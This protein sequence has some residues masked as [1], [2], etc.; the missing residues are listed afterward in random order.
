MVTRAGPRAKTVAVISIGEIP[1]ELY[2][3][4]KGLL[5]NFS[6]LRVRDSRRKT[7]MLRNGRKNGEKTSL[8]R[9]AI[10]PRIFDG[11]SSS[12]KPG[13]V[14]E[15]IRRGNMDSE[16]VVGS[17][18]EKG[19]FGYVELTPESRNH[20]HFSDKVMLAW[21]WERFIYVE[22][23]TNALFMA[24]D[25]MRSRYIYS[26]SDIEH[27]ALGKYPEI[28]KNMRTVDLLA[29]LVF[30][31]NKKESGDQSNMPGRFLRN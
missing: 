10:E 24:L 22:P 20:M 27:T 6:G 28:A 3:D 11:I 16:M 14:V 29:R 4:A 23:P 30:A 1:A 18:K 13:I 31:I 2:L 21:K 25:E 15:L 17:Q 12:Y 26:V 9:F 7:D 19:S 8:R 5:G